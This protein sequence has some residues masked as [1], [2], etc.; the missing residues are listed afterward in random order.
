MA[1]KVARKIRAHDVLEV[2]ADLFVRHGPPEYLRSD[3]G[4]EFTAKLVR[5]WLARLGVQ[6]LYI[7]PGSPWE[8][9]YNES[10]NGKLRDELLNGEIF[11]SLEEAKVLTEQWRREYNT[12]RPHSSLRYRPPAPEALR[13]DPFFLNLPKLNGPHPRLQEAVGL[14]Q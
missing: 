13:P 6:T 4:P 10:F 9:G 5:Q 11:Y 8:N 3:N 12:I 14:T 7:E 2:L 1:I